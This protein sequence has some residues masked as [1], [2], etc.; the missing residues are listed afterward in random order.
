MDSV[1][2]ETIQRALADVQDTF[3]VYNEEKEEQRLRDLRKEIK[4]RQCEIKHLTDTLNDVERAAELTA[5]TD[6]SIAFVFRF[7]ADMIR[8]EIRQKRPDNLIFKVE[9]LEKRKRWI[10]MIG[11]AL[12]D[13]G[14]LA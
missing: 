12:S 8:E 10:T 4:T 6:L 9:Q 2:K 3:S 11:R 14:D 5:P 7:R 13:I 1:D